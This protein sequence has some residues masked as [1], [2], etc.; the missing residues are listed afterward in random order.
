MYIDSLSFKP[1]TLYR[2]WA[3]LQQSRTA[4]EIVPYKNG[5][6]DNLSP[7]KFREKNSKGSTHEEIHFSTEI[8]S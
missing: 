4:I 3:R 2:V 5:H 8:A 7:S 6:G 1:D